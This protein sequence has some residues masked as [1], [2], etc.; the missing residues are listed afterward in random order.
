MSESDRNLADRLSRGDLTAFDEIYELYYNRVYS[1]S[2]SYL[3]RKEDAEGVV[4]DVF[5]TLWLKRSELTEIRNLKGWLFTITFNRVRKIFRNLAIERKNMDQF[6]QMSSAVDI[7]TEHSLEFNDLFEKAESYIDRLSP[8]QQSVLL[9]QVKE[10][11]E[12]DEIAS[13]LKINKRTVDNH[14]NSARKALLQILRDEKIIPF[15]L[16][17]FLVF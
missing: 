8:R 5:E 14:L 17:W 15:L 4:Q 6:G 2:F 16:M 9:L 3:K 13:R 12:N 11:L 7:S 10:G 1:F